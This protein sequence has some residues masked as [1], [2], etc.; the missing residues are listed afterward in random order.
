MLV[1]GNAE[2]FFTSAGGSIETTPLAISAH[3]PT[4]T[5]GVLGVPVPGVSLKL[6]HVDGYL[7]TG[8]AGLL[9]DPDRPEAGVVFAG[10]IEENFKLSSGTWVCWTAR[11]GP[12]EA[13][14]GGDPGRHPRHA[15]PCTEQE[16]VGATRPPS[17]SYVSCGPC[18]CR[19]CRSGACGCVWVIGAWW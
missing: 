3:F 19:W 11:A 10:R 17:L 14:D 5:A 1:A 2:L 13:G 4:P 15:R 9:V 6:A 16:W 7:P 12:A 8:D 18:V